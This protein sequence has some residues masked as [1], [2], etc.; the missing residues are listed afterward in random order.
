M[1]VFLYMRVSSE[2]QARHGY[3]LEA[4]YEAL[5][6]FC[7]QN[8][9][10]VLGVYRDEGVSG[11][12]P[13]IKRP[14]MIQLLQDVETIKPD[15]ILFTR[16]DRWFRNVKEYYRVEDI[17]QRNHV[18]WK[19]IS[20]EYD[21]S[22]ASGRLYVNV[23]LAI[24]ENEA[25][26]TGER[27]KDIQGQKIAQG[28]WLGGRTPFG[29]TLSEDNHLIFDDN[30][31]ILREAIDYYLMHQALKTTVR[32]INDAHGTNF[33]YNRL[34]WAFSQPTLKGEYR[35]NPNFCEPL[36][37]PEEFDR[38]QDLLKRNNIKYNTKRIYLFTG[39]L[40][41]PHCGKNMG[42]V[43]NGEKDKRIK[44]Y[45]CRYC[46]DGLCDY[47]THIRESR[48]EKWL[49]ENIEED[50]KVNVTMK[51]K[52]KREDPK[53]YRDRLKRLNDMYLMGNI[54]EAEYRE[55]SADIQ[56]KIAELSKIAPLKTQNFASNWKEVYA[57][58]DDEHK[59]SFWR[60]LITEIVVNEQLQGFQIVY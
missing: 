27:I 2:E 24:A 17:L 29:Y 35:G 11:K 34:K 14:A 12:K 20:E 10:V 45:R 16:L 22:T 33:T 18:Y 60:N 26:R 59:R 6:D 21:T 36:V 47:K 49:L 25:D 9:H 55:K 30:I 8:N 46:W 15:M 40:K 57:L 1:K 48:L 56:K 58:L 19:S 13:F 52:E 32:H 31:H 37:T 43:S 28:L 41:C 44:Y 51:P 23:R 54:S 39:L 7:K 4:Q 38:L 53:K 3:S 42:G 50:F 5:T